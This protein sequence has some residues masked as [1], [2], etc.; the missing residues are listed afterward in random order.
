M[1]QSLQ[2]WIASGIVYCLTTASPDQVQVVPVPSMR[3]MAQV[4]PDTN[5]FK[6]NPSNTN[7]N[8]WEVGESEK[9]LMPTCSTYKG[10]ETSTFFITGRGG[11]PP[12]PRET[13]N[14]TDE[15]LVDL[16]QPTLAPISPLPFRESDRTQKRSSLTVS[17]TKNLLLGVKPTT[18]MEA[19]GWIINFNGEVSLTAQTN[20][21]TPSS[22]RFAPVSC[23]TTKKLHLEL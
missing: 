17:P 12:D 19:Q 4:L 3:L 8:L 20:T 14:S 10:Q 16:G 21:I 6:T 2:L 5:F 13:V 15:V 11:L 22:P 18:L 9:L 1:K 23:H 7:T